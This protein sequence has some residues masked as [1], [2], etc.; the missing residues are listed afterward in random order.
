MDKTIEIVLVAVVAMIA[1]LVVIFLLQGRAD[2]FGGFL[3]DQQEGSQCEIWKA[4]YR[5]QC[6]DVSQNLESKFGDSCSQ[7]AC[8]NT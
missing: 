1:A 6:P 2:S 5:N 7:P 3:D 8:P 4:Q